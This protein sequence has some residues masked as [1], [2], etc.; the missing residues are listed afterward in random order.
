MCEKQVS[1]Q[2]D[3]TSTLTEPLTRLG[4]P[5]N[6]TDRGGEGGGTRRLSSRRP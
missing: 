2:T 6:L 3:V 1:L 5:V 4:L